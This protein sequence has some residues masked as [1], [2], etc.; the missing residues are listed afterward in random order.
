M[1]L[2]GAKY[3]CLIVRLPRGRGFKFLKEMP[4]SGTFR[5]VIGYAV[6]PD[7]GGQHRTI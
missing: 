3:K 4:L 5:D 7:L 1:T 6:R 2:Y